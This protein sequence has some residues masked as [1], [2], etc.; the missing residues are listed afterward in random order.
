MTKSVDKI[1]EDNGLKWGTNYAFL[2]FA[3][4]ISTILNLN[5]WAYYYLQIKAI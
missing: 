1:D 4:Q 2:L 3:Q 5:N